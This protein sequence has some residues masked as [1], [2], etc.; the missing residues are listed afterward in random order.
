[1][2]SHWFYFWLEYFF[3]EIP[4]DMC[5]LTLGPKDF[6]HVI[7]TSWGR[8]DG[9]EQN[10]GCERMWCVMMC[11]ADLKIIEMH[12]FVIEISWKLS[13]WF[14]VFLDVTRIFQAETVIWCNLYLL[15]VGV[16]EFTSRNS[17]FKIRTAVG[18]RS[19]QPPC[20]S[21][22]WKLLQLPHGTA[23]QQID[24]LNRS[25]SSGWYRMLKYWWNM[26]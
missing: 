21:W 20:I 23:P 11:L 3:D 15:E 22:P 5:R 12:D 4:P 7:L 26:I 13:K 25:G 19:Y 16:L 9:M 14:P 24:C 2:E 17:T 8:V 10:L 1:M 18:L 6:A